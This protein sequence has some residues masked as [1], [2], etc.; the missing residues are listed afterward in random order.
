MEYRNVV[1]IS[2]EKQTQYLIEN[3]TRTHSKVNQKRKISFQMYI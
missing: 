2:G 1:L 3:E